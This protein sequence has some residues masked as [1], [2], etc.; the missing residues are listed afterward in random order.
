[1]RHWIETGL[2]AAALLL[3]ALSPAQAQRKPA[4]APPTCAGQDMVGEIVGRD[5][6]TRRRVETAAAATANAKSIFWRVEK[7]GVEPSHLFGTI[8][9]TDDRVNALPAAVT[10]ALD[11]ARTVAL[12]IDDLSPAKIGAA[13]GRARGLLMF[14]D[15]RTLDAMLTPDEL[16]IALTAME[17]AGIPREALGAFRPWFVT[18]S[19]AIPECERKRA[20]SGLKPLDQRLGDRARERKI[21]VVGLETIEDQLQALAATPEADQL[22]LLK[23]GLRTHHRLAD[24][25][26]TLV[27][28]YL[29]RDLGVIWPIQQELWRQHGAPQSAAD[30]FRRELLTKR[31]VT[32]RDAALPHLTK[33]RAFIAVGALHLPGDDGLVAL[34]RGA[35]FTVTAAE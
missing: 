32:M 26:E 8:H 5:A 29:A 17:N 35:G 22:S 4:V 15:G 6:D 34:L 19:L 16:S 1:M 11:A 25:I 28:R 7:P 24:H 9:L 27:Q 13:I 20:A 3:A 18:M 10:A 30:A 14:Q 31:N 2:G 23:A 12:E 33:G 21:P